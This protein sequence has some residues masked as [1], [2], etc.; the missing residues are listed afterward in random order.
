MSQFT[1]VSYTLRPHS[2]AVCSTCLQTFNCVK[3]RESTTQVTAE[4]KTVAQSNNKPVSLQKQSL[5]DTVAQ[6]NKAVL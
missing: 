4:M 6:H 3:T 1:R 2:T 5:V